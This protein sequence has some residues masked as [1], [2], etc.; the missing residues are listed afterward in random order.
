[1]PSPPTP[2][3]KQPYM[4]WI[5]STE[6]FGYCDTSTYIIPVLGENDATR[7][8]GQQSNT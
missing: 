5:F 7:N 1:M 6:L 3:K 2:A 4:T 8:L